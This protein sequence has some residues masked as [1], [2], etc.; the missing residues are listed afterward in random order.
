M[1]PEKTRGTLE[2]A[3]K[4]GGE[5]IMDHQGTA[6]ETTRKEK[7]SSV[8]TKADLAAEKAILEILGNTSFPCNIISEESGFMD[9]GAS[10]TWVVDPLDGTS[11][12]A[13]GLPW[14]GVIIALFHE[15]QPVLGGMHLPLEKAYYMAEMGKGATLNGTPLRIS[16]A[17]NLE[18]ILVAYS[19]DFSDTPGKTRSEM[20]VM[21]R[22]SERVRNIR[23]TNSLVDFCYTARGWLG[24]AVNQTTKIWD[25]AAPWLLIREA[26]GVV[27]DITGKDLRF[28]LSAGSLDRNYTIVAAC[29]GV[30][31]ELI[32]LIQPT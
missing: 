11:N 18:E 28:D 30:H 12:F 13:A 24:G 20:Q 14:F 23:S 15:D 25:I 7:I 17:S 19:F 4:K 3:L 8:V 29:P 2:T 16:E 9:R 31:R 6:L 1:F 26:G 27:T 32:K 10:R 5:V 21:E 22:L